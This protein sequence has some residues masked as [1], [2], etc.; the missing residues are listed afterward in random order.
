MNAPLPP[1][2]PPNPNAGQ[3]IDWDRPVGYGHAASILTLL[4]LA[5]DS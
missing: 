4:T 1:L 3:S 5:K 2:T